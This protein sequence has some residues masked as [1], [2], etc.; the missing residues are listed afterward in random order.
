[1]QK[2]DGQDGKYSQHAKAVFRGK[3]L[4]ICEDETNTAQ[5]LC[6]L[7]RQLGMRILETV[8]TGG[9]AMQIARRHR[10]E[11]IFMNTLLPDMDG[12]SA[13]LEILS[14]YLPCIILMT[15]LAQ[16]QVLQ[17]LVGVPIGGVLTKP[18]VDEDLLVLLQQQRAKG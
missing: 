11:F 17:R 8:P 7:G 9:E 18:I 13:A 14:F 15:T 3:Q 10:P 4:L 5:H 16:E 6:R 2:P 1:M 12:I